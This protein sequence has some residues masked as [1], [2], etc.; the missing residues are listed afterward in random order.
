M[1]GLQ[2]NLTK[3]N[4][5]NVIPSYFNQSAIFN[6]TMKFSPS[7]GQSRFAKFIVMCF[8]FFSP[9]LFICGMSG[10]VNAVKIGGIRTINLIDHISPPLFLGSL[11]FQ[12]L[13]ERGE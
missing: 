3:E 12:S 5:F 11:F 7:M 10:L 2:V 1:I 9:S 13:G 8:S 4:L 6:L